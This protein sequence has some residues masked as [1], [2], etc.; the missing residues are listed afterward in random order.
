MDS[1]ARAQAVRLLVLDVDGVLTNGG[2]TYD[3]QGEQLQTFHV[4]D[5]MGLRL[6]RAAGVETAI[7][8]GRLSAPAQARARDLGIE[9]LYLNERYKKPVLQALL[10]R[11]GLT[12]AQ[13]AYMGDD[14]NDIPCLQIVGLAMAPADAAW[15]VR[16][17]C[18]F[19]SGYPGGGG[20]VR[21]ACQMIMQAQ[22]T[23]E[24][25]AGE[26]FQ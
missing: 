17:I 14:L 6:L 20:A 2:I 5:G 24:K 4:R 16:R 8:S 1:Q 10:E 19:I 25:T 12:L 18:H 21:E 13:T 7:I 26:Y 23:W 3:C 22:G 9:H 11:L 15:E